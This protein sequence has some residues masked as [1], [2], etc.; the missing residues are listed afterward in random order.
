MKI[1]KLTDRLKHVTIRKN[2]K[3][4]IKYFCHTCRREKKKRPNVEN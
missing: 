3:E 4:K 1:L 2:K